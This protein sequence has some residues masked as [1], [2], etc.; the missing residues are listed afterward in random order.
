VII[1]EIANAYAPIHVL[2]PCSH[3]LDTDGAFLVALDVFTLR[4]K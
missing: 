3:L 4:E 1:L 2:T